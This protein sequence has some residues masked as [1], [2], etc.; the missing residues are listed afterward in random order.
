LHWELQLPPITIADSYVLILSVG[1][2]FGKATEPGEI[3]IMDHVGAAKV[4]RCV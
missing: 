2:Q 4:L 1:I 3:D